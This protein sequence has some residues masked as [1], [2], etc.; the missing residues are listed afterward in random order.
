MF[1]YLSFVITISLFFI[2]CSSESGNIDPDIVQQF[3][4]FNI[5]E[6]EIGDVFKYVYAAGEDFRDPTNLDFEYT[7]D[8]LVLEVVD[9]VEGQFV[10]RESITESSNM[11]KSVEPYFFN[12]DTIYENFWFVFN[13]QLTIRTT[14]MNIFPGSHLLFDNIN[15]PLN[16]FDEMELTYDGWKPK[17]SFDNIFSKEAYTKNLELHGTT[18]DFLNVWVNLLGLQV[19]APGKLYTY[20]KEQG[21]VRTTLFYARLK[22]GYNWERI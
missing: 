13:D 20:S 11:H 3:K 4:A 7:G 12:K 19:D 6:L 22:N 5:E 8:T 15:L 9:Q 16:V 14:G 2:Q 17:E 10:I 18:Y 21:I 1:K